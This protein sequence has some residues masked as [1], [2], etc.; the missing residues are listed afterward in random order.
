MSLGPARPLLAA[1]R[2]QLRSF[3]PRRLETTM[4]SRRFPAVV[5]AVTPLPRI[6][7]GAEL[8]TGAWIS[9]PCAAITG[10]NGK[11]IELTPDQ[12]QL[13]RGIYAMNLETPPGL[14][15]GD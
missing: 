1:D 13:L 6:A 3:R 15:C 5:G 14:P 10:D 2:S 4:S 9:R 11:I 12:W 7:F 8:S